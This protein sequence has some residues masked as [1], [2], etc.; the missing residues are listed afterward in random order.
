MGR[1]QLIAIALGTIMFAS[2]VGAQ[3]QDPRKQGLAEISGGPVEISECQAIS[4]SG[5]YKLVNNLT[6]QQGADCLTVTATGAVTID[7]AGFS[8]TANP[9]PG[10]TAI[11][12]TDFTVIRNGAISGFN[13]GIQGADVVEGLNITGSC[14]PPAP[15]G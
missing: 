6:A 4:E 10:G 14:G 2:A 12:G 9:T 8:I 13:I 3:A 5:S 15:T 11:K 1:L 7:L